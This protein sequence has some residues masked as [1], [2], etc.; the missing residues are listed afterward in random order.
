LNIFHPDDE[1]SEDPNYKDEDGC[2]TD[3]F[4]EE[5][6]NKKDELLDEVLSFTEQID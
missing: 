2:W 5:M 4:F 6:S 3:A 1:Y